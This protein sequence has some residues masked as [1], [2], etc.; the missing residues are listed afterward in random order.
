MINLWNRLRMP[1]LSVRSR[2]MRSTTN[3]RIDSGW[4]LILSKKIVIYF[5][6]VYIKD[7]KI[8]KF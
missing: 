7:T 2:C 1:N 6:Y 4:K 5:D 3:G 8:I